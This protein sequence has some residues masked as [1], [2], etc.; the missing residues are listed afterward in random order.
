MSFIDVVDT[1]METFLS[2][3]APDTS[4][5][6]EIGSGSFTVYMVCANPTCTAVK[7]EK[8]YP[9]SIACVSYKFVV[10]LEEVLF[11]FKAAIHHPVLLYGR[12]VYILSSSRMVTVSSLGMPTT[13]T[14]GVAE[15]T[16]TPKLWSPSRAKSCRMTMST[17]EVEPSI[18][19]VGNVA[20]S[21]PAT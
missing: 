20:C 14:E 21:G 9:E 3:T 2:K 11:S 17:H 15:I 4:M 12:R 7:K 5:H 6:T 18:L 1:E 8:K 19:L 10:G 16:S 13:T